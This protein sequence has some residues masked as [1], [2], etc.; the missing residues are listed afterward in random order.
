MVQPKCL[1]YLCNDCYLTG[2]I[3]YFVKVL[4]YHKEKNN[5]DISTVTSDFYQGNSINFEKYLDIFGAKYVSLKD[6]DIGSY[7]YVIAYYGMNPLGIEAEQYNRRLI[8]NLESVMPKAYAQK[9][10]NHKINECCENAYNEL[11]YYGV[12]ADK[13]IPCTLLCKTDFTIEKFERLKANPPTFISNNCCS[14]YIYFSLGIP[15]SSPFV[16][17]RIKSKDHLK[18]LKEPKRFINGK[19]SP[20]GFLEKGEEKIPM[21]KLESDNDQIMIECSHYKIYEDFEKVWNKRKKRI[22]YNNIISILTTENEEDLEEFSKLDSKKICFLRSEEDS[23][24]DITRFN[25]GI[26]KVNIEQF[27]DAV[28]TVY[29]EFLPKDDFN[30]VA[31]HFGMGYFPFFSI[32]DFVVTGKLSYTEDYDNAANFSILLTQLVW[33]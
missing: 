33:G 17:I 14:R 18:I 10:I 19:L 11:T 12:N 2:V 21:A 6:L 25:E 28:L 1:V 5:L 20:A 3:E 29:K 16:N 22:N 32:L 9:R 26:V 7:D 23:I 4:A 13:I 27:S 31:N 24:L 8:G 15:F 30:S